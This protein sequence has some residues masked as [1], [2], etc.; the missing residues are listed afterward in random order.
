MEPVLFRKT[1]DTKVVH[2]GLTGSCATITE[3]QYTS[4]GGG[5]ANRNLWHVGVPNAA[6]DARLKFDGSTSIVV[7]TKLAI[8]IRVGTL[9]G[10][11]CLGGSSATVQVQIVA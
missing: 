7:G 8:T 6:G 5:S 4:A 10:G 3:V 9:S 11:N 2:L 1:G